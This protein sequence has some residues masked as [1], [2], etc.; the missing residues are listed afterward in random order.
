MSKTII[1]V[2]S[3]AGLYGYLYRDAKKAIKGTDASVMINLNKATQLISKKNSPVKRAIIICGAKFNG[4]MW[5]TV[6]VYSYLKE[7]FPKLTFVIMESWKWPVRK[8]DMIVTLPGSHGLSDTI[9]GY[10]L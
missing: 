7:R 9:K 4:K 2:P 8:A 5:G 6:E 3:I 1:L 10:L